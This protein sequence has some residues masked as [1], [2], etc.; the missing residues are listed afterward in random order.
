MNV[1]VVTRYT[2]PMVGFLFLYRILSCLRIFTCSVQFS[3]SVVSDS[4]RSH[5]LQHARPPCPSPT[6]RAYSNSCALSRWCHPTISFSVIPFSSHLQFFSASGSFPMSQF[7]PSDG[8]S[9]GALASA[10][11]KKQ[12]WYICIASPIINI[13][14]HSG[15]FITT[16]EPKL[17]HHYN[18]KFMAYTRADSWCCVSYGFG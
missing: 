12:I 11:V 6:P 7:F 15:T 9:I 8:Q 16:D 10:S 14:Y 3:C 18:P 2:R 13:L 5:G 17:T 1:L 4:L